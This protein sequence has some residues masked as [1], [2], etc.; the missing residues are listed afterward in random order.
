L[1][2]VLVVAYAWLAWRPAMQ[3]QAAGEGWIA[4]LSGWIA[5]GQWH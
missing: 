1:Y 2:L 4:K 3:E 5:L